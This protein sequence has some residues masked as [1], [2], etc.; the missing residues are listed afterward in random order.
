MN[1]LFDTVAGGGAPGGHIHRVAAEDAEE[2]GVLLDLGQRVLGP[3]LRQGGLEVHVEEVL[4][5]LC[6]PGAA[7]LRLHQPY[8]AVPVRPRLNLRQRYVPES[9]RR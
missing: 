9:E 3:R 1:K 4:E 7:V 8:G 5:V 6:H 2:G